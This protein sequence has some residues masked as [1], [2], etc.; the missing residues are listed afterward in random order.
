MTTNAINLNP[1]VINFAMGLLAERKANLT[2]SSANEE[3]F[4]VSKETASIEDFFKETGLNID[5]GQD[6]I[7]ILFNIL[8]LL[9]GVDKNKET[10]NTNINNSIAASTNAAE[11]TVP[12]AAIPQKAVPEASVVEAAAPEETVSVNNTKK[13]DKTAETEANSQY[14]TLATRNSVDEFAKEHSELFDENTTFEE[15][16]KTFD[17]LA[18]KGEIIENTA[19]DSKDTTT[20]AL[21]DGIYL[22]KGTVTDENGE[23][24]DIRE[25]GSVTRF[26]STRNEKLM[27]H[28]KVIEDNEVTDY[29][30]GF[31]SLSSTGNVNE[32]EVRTT[33]LDNISY[34][35]NC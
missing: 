22:K 4:P 17:E 23:K 34:K 9:F 26:E 3:I 5:T 7:Q 2:S 12:E 13:I 31:R 11:K 29:N 1:C 14:K 10:I 8:S 20:I 24:R 30:Y 33:N 21:G 28:G 16:N 27:S 19:W 15:Y 32:E 6:P 25:V 35:G 18:K